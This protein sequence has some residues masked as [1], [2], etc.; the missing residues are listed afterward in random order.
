MAR[1]RFVSRSLPL[2][3]AG[4]AAAAAETTTEELFLGTLPVVLSVSRLSQP[5]AEAPGAVT[6]LERQLILRSG[7]RTLAELLRLVP[8]FLVASNEYGAPVATYHGP[9]EEFP[10][11]MQVL[12]DG[13]SQYAPAFL[14]GVN[15]SGLA[16]TIEEIERIEVTRG[17]NSAAY[18]SNAF[19]GI[20]NVITRDPALTHGVGLSA[21]QGEG[22]IEDRL[23]RLGG[24]V[25]AAEFRVVASAN[26]D[27]GLP[28]QF[29]SLRQRHLN[30]R[31][32]L[33][34]GDRD[35]LIF[36][37]GSL[38]GN[39]AI[40]GTPNSGTNPRR[41]PRPI[42]QDFAQLEW[43]HTFD[44]DTDLSLR[45]FQVEDFGGEVLRLAVVPATLDFRYR[46][47]RHDFEAQ[48]T[49]ALSPALR[50]VSGVG[51]RVDRFH[52]ASDFFGMSDPVQR[53]S[54]LFGNLEW[55]PATAW[56]VNLGATWE[57]DSNSGTSLAPRLTLHRRVAAGQWLRA[58][59]ARAYRTPSLFEQVGRTHYQT[60]D[61]SLV[62]W[63]NIGRRDLRPERL[64]TVELG[65]VAE[66]PAA[67]SSLDLRLARERT[68]RGLL[69]VATAVPPDLGP[70]FTNSINSTYNGFHG[71][72]DSI[73]MQLRWQPLEA[74]RL[75]LNH[76]S[77]RMR[78][79]VN[80]TV[81]EE[82]IDAAY[83][84]DLVT[85]IPD[86][87]PDYVTSLIWLQQ[88]SDGWR[89][90]SAFRRVGSMRWTPAVGNSVPA[91]STVDWNVSWQF[92][93]GRGRGEVA[94]GVLAD[95]SPHAEFRR[96]ELVERRAYATVRLEL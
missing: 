14:G 44:A 83:L 88:L 25:G 71:T 6:V 20:V 21:T 5:A 79:D 92:I 76:A 30:L 87:V 38:R 49:T 91:Y 75:I 65:Y 12:V 40:E 72:L 4:A 1:R 10:Q 70:D 57:H 78:G 45:Y 31:T 7:A 61:G 47:R 22:G 86:S 33:R 24:R 46:S 42:N 54:R 9:A 36:N 68:R 67:R 2:L 32:D 60:D 18:G 39:L 41:D 8:G 69:N 53:I 56:R 55:Q 81:R 13:R 34:L 37:G 35:L 84:N 63:G 62:E 48:L 80:D 27:D 82:A 59:L 50:L 93:A 74:T 95:S 17:S 94:V 77:M 52:H 11:G 3:L 89:L 90:T 29:D 96:D 85:Q 15:W 19:L 26:R 64:D 58:G 73:E 66:F 43:L 16:V 28:A 23:V 51:H